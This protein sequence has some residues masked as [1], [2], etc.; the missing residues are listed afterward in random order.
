MKKKEKKF[1]FICYLNTLLL[2]DYVI[3]NYAEYKRKRKL[4]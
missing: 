4:F 2:V 3:M 1:L